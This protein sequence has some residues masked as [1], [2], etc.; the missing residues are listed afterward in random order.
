MLLIKAIQ[1]F[2]YEFYRTFWSSLGIRT[3]PQ[4]VSGGEALLY[5][6]A[7]ESALFSLLVAFFLM[8]AI[9]PRYIE[10]PR[11][12][13]IGA[14]LTVIVALLRNVWMHRRRRKQLCYE[15]LLYG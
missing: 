12:A 7:G 2:L 1:F 13:L 10:S 11:T 5:R 6:I 4:R 15:E 8:N 14:G 9:A 3:A